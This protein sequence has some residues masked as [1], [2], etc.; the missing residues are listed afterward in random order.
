MTEGRDLDEGVEI[1][2]N[3][4]AIALRE[5]TMS[6]MHIGEIGDVTIWRQVRECSGILANVTLLRGR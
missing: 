5:I 3:E 4:K 2:R 6:L 1:L